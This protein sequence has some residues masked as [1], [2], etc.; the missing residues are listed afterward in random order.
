MR[1]VGNMRKNTAGN[2]S[3]QTDKAVFPPGSIIPENMAEDAVMY[4]QNPMMGQQQARQMQQNTGGAA[5]ITSANDNAAAHTRDN[6][7][8]NNESIHGLMDYDGM[9][10]PFSGGGVLRRVDSPDSN[11]IGSVEDPRGFSPANGLG[12]RP[13]MNEGNMSENMSGNMSQRPMR[14]MQGAQGS[15]I[16]GPGVRLSDVMCMYSGKNVEIE[17][18][19]GAD[20][21]VKKSGIISGAGMNF[22]ILTDPGT[23]RKTVCDLTD[24][25]F[26]SISEQ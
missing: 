3:N 13:G 8:D 7:T 10:F 19:F 23:G 16:C 4:G 20:T 1:Y 9:E 12:G 6:M 17:F 14:P 25:K 26:V 24:M 18:L 2:F 21:Y 11:F 15:M 5:E 22:V